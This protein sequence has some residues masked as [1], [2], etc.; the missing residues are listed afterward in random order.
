[1]AVPPGLCDVCG[2]PAHHRTET[3]TGRLV[4]EDCADDIT[5]STA[6]VLTGGTGLP[7]DVGETVAIRGWMRRAR[8]WRLGNRGHRP[9]RSGS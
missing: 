1:M 6:A 2:T 7:A 9:G 4:C 3:V 5:A 8:Q